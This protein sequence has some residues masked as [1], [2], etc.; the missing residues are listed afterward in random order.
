MVSCKAKKSNGLRCKNVPGD[1]GYC[2][3]H[4]PKDQGEPNVSDGEENDDDIMSPVDQEPTLGVLYQK[5]NALT[6]KVEQLELRLSTSGAP[7][8]KPRNLTMAGKLKKAKWIFY[9]ENKANE[10]IFIDLKTKLQA[11]GW[12]GEKVPW[13][14]KKEYTDAV[15][16]TFD[17]ANKKVYIDKI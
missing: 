4:R 15:F 9:N 16:D 17:E 14:L 11:A 8:K 10:S 6:T 7:V 13:L 12:V 1:D 2:S 3:K 5:V